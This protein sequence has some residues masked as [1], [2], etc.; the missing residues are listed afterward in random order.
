[1]KFYNLKTRSHVEIADADVK[2]KQMKRQTKSGEQI[3]YAFVANH[4]G[5]PLHKFVKKED[6][7]ALDVAEVE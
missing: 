3:R 6:F 4:E 2:K 5:T 1:M 7:D